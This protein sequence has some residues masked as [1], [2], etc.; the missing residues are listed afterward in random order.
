LPGREAEPGG[1]RE[2]QSCREHVAETYEE[3]VVGLRPCFCLTLVED[4]RV[5]VVFCRE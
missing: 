4:R 5:R 3:R 1:A 2:H